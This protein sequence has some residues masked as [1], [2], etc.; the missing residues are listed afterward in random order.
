MSPAVRGLQSLKSTTQPAASIHH[1]HHHRHCRRRRRRRLLCGD[2]SFPLAR[3]STCPLPGRGLVQ[4]LPVA[5]PAAADARRGRSARAGSTHALR[6]HQQHYLPAGRALGSWPNR[7]RLG[8]CF[9]TPFPLQSPLHPLC[10]VAVRKVRK[11]K[12][13]NCLPPVLPALHNMSMPMDK[14]DSGS[15][16]T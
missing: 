7:R 2:G 3:P 15:I 6:Q 16:R 13:P 14:R 5:F 11:E 10:D 8:N 9:C 12:V 1:H 4:N